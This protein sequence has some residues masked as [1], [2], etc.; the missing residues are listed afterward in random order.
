MM[1]AASLEHNKRPRKEE[2]DTAAV[3]TQFSLAAREHRELWNTSTDMQ[4]QSILALDR[5][6]RY[7]NSYLPD[8]YGII[9]SVIAVARF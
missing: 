9:V 7:L 2:V 4:L 1:A 6:V 8:Y 3:V 5:Y